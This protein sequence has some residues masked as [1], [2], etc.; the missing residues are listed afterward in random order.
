MFLRN[1]TDMSTSSRGKAI[2]VRFEC[3]GAAEKK[4]M[5]QAFALENHREHLPH[6]YTDNSSFAAGEGKC[7]LHDRV[8]RVDRRRADLMIAG[9]PCQPFSRFRP[10]SG[11]TPRTGPASEH[12]SFESVFGGFFDYVV[13]RSAWGIIIEEVKHMASEYV[14]GSSQ[15]YLQAMANKLATM[16][17]DIRVVELDHKIFCQ[18]ARPRI[19]LVAI[20]AELGGT[21]AANYIASVVQNR[22]QRHSLVY[23]QHRKSGPAHMGRTTLQAEGGRWGQEEGEMGQPSGW[24]GPGR[25]PG[26]DSQWRH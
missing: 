10:R 26:A 23:T 19:L 22:E 17:Y 12:P 20:G 25:G 13:A 21:A 15:T 4:K 16:G 2:G 14:H 24:P 1:R 5:A 18:M 11:A 3:L 6:L 9:L 7:I 8:C